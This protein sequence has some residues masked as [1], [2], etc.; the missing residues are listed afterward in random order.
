[1]RVLLTGITGYI[2]SAVAAALAKGGFKI[3]GLIRRPEQAAALQ[4]KGYEALPGDLNRPETF[5]DRIGMFDA[6]VHV[7]FDYQQGGGTADE[8]AVDAFL[9]AARGPILYTSGVWVYGGTGGKRVTEWERPNPLSVVAWRPGVEK[10]VLKHP[11]GM[12][13]RPGCVY[14]GKGGLLASLWKQAEAGAVT[15]VGDGS[16][17]WAKIHRDDL[18]DVYL[19]VMD[20]R[21]LGSVYNA[22]DGDECTMQQMAEAMLQAA[23]KPTGAVTAVPANPS[24]PFAQALSVDQRI[25]SDKAKRELLWTPKFSFLRDVA[26]LYTE[27]KS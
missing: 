24:D 17:R 18:A 7:G 6:I 21:P 12:V 14:G 13:I 10:K 23:G 11:M 25:S 2:G 26:K 1:M 27:W 16:N 5:A 15:L 20:K 8:L 22:T 9:R 4:A 19:K 3:T